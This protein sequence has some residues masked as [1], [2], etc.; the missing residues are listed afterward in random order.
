MASKVEIGRFPRL[1]NGNDCE[2]KP[3][4]RD[5]KEVARIYREVEWTKNAGMSERYTGRVTGYR[6]EAWADESDD[7]MGH[8]AETLAEA[9]AI[10]RK[11]V[12]A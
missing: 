7:Y 6:V 3:V 5:G 10:A 12:D 4:F 8:P 2:G 11:L 1:E 9:H